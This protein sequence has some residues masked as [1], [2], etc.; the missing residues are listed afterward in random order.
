MTCPRLRKRKQES[1]RFHTNLKNK[2]GHLE[3]KGQKKKLKNL[4]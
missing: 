2:Q 4:I 3:N 1:D